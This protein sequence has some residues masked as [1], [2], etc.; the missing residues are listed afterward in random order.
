MPQKIIIGFDAEWVRDPDDEARNIVL[1]Y[2]Y[3]GRTDKGEWSNIIYTD[4]EQQSNRLNMIDLFGQAIEEGRSKKLIPN[5]WPTDV[6]AAAHFSR[7]DLSAFMDFKDIR[8]SFDSVSNTFVTLTH[9]YKA[10]YYDKSNNKHPL[11]IHLID[12]MLLT[13]GGK[14]LAHL[15]DLYDFPKIT[16]PVGMIN[17][18]DELLKTDP[19]LFKDYAIRDAEISCRHAWKMMEFAEEHFDKDKPP[20][21]LGNI[22]VKHVKAIWEKENIDIAEVVGTEKHTEAEYS[23]NTGR[24]HTKTR[25]VPLV[26][27]HENYAFA[28]ECFHGGRNEGFVFG[29]SEINIDWQDVDLAGAY[30]TAMSAIKIP[31][32]KNLEDTKSVGD[33]KPDVLGLARVQFKFPDDTRFPCLPVRSGN[34]LIFPL[35]GVTTIASPELKLALDMGAN[36]TIKRGL[37]IPWKSEVRPFELFSKSVRDMRL[38]NEKG[39]VD[40]Q[41]WKEIGNSLYGKTAQGLRPRRVFDGRSSESRLLPPCEVTQPFLA[42]YITSLVRAVISEMLHRIPDDKTVVSVTTDGFITDAVDIDQSGPLCQIFSELR[43]RISDDPAI[44][45]VKHRATQVCCMKTR[46]QVS[47]PATG[48]EGKPISAKAGVKL[49]STYVEESQQDKDNWDID[50]PTGMGMPVPSFWEDNAE[51]AWMLNAFLD[52]TYDTTFPMSSLVSMRD[53]FE[54]D[55]DLVSEERD[56]RLNLDFDWKRELIDPEMREVH[57]PRRTSDDYGAPHHIFAKSKPW[58]SAEEF[59]TTRT[60][61]DQWRYQKKSVLKTFDDW[62]SWR[63]YFQTGEVSAKGIRRGEGGLVDQAKRTI[64]HAYVKR[65]WGLPGGGYKKIAEYLTNAG[66]PTSENDLKN[67]GRKKGSVVENA[68]PPDKEVI[69]LVNVMTQRYPD[70][71][72]KFVFTDLDDVV[73]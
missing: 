71:Q 3:A 24:K 55:L 51:A 28:T 64:L 4:G 61:F 34:G 39:S 69:A 18:M 59:N 52:R 19:K 31:D 10:N 60:R 14:S 21:T 62:N 41:T 54:D 72:W 45:E 53:M 42:A 70:F 1:S 58:K 44:L 22:S 40:E 67:A 15:G 23:K 49:P 5:K 35:E 25:D 46:G 30:T 36:I 57:S 9:P 73:P 27:V 66:Y 48:G 56:I 26:E 68:F 20:S 6:Y 65:L 8:G 12:T 63:E 17:K 37:V 50:D 7:A 33:F 16:L 13:P 29:F 2:Q 38:S 32:Y 47:V 43:E 11:S